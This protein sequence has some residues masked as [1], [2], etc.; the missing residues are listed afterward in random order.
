MQ[1]LYPG[2]LAALGF[3]AIPIIIHLFN[4]VR[5]KKIYFSNVRFLKEIKEE[6]KSRSKL[7]HLLILLA[8]MLALSFLVLAFSQPFIPLKDTLV[9]PGEK[10]VSIYL[11]NS[12]S[13]AATGRNGTLLDEAK[14][15]AEAIVNAFGNTD[16]FQLLTNDFM[17]KHQ[18]WVN[19]KTFMEMLQ[20]VKVSPNTRLLPEIISRQNDMFAT[21]NNQ[22]KMSYII[23]DFQLP[24]FSLEH[25]KPDSLV[26]Y[27]MIHLS[28]NKM[29]NVYIDSCWFDTP[30]R[31][32]NQAEQLHVRIVNAGDEEVDNIP[33]KLLINGT[34]RTVATASVKAESSTEIDLVY[35]NKESGIIQ[36][37][38]QISDYPVTYD[39]DY[40]FSYFVNKKV[41]LLIM[42]QNDE[43]VYLNK[44]FGSDS[45]FE[46]TQSNAK[47]IDYGSLGN[48]DLV[49]LC[50]IDEISSGLSDELKKNIRKG[51][52][53]LIFP[54]TKAYLNEYNNF[55]SDFSGSFMP[56][57]TISVKVN[58]INFKHPLFEGVFDEAKMKRENLN[59]PLVSKHY[60]FKIS[61][62]SNQEWLIDLTNSDIFMMQFGLDNGKLYLCTSPLNEQYNSFPRH[63]LFVPTLY[64][65]AISGGSSDP[66]FYTIGR[67]Q[68]I[69][70][71]NNNVQTD[72]VYH[73][74]SS[75]QKIEFIA[76]VKSNGFSTYLNTEKQINEAGNYYLKNNA[77]DTLKGLSFNFNRLE[78]QNKYYSG[79]DI[80]NQ[81]ESY[82][83][84]NIKIIEKGVK[85]MT[86]AISDLSKEIQL[87]KWCVLLALIFLGAEIAIIRWMK[88]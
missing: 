18:H 43:N 21:L 7:K 85:N 50:N 5:Y 84:K 22:A 72:P 62:K 32:Y 12:F 57:D 46:V 61:N 16:K 59:L 17:G 70:L 64:K 31:Q 87:W 42:N 49:I 8:R 40:Y 11:D 19:K 34:Q 73:I 54:G 1:F 83:F 45:L 37:H 13:M 10:A 41:R 68:N 48:Y 4:F 28:G 53:V 3:L 75:N 6:T 2:F 20:E 78:S 27:Q 77:N 25:I 66:L 82:K 88:G 29:S 14:S 26:N 56:I 30:T 74:N 71:K 35:S 86:A 33:I 76:E 47:N 9:N 44:L 23:S 24:S 38:I 65:M 80:A 63:A 79:N 81:I 67:T 51:L 69:E 60:P 39:N 36:G 15:D 52:S 58:R 55:L